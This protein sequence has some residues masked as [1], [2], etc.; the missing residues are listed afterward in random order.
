MDAVKRHRCWVCGEDLGVYDRRFCERW[1]TCGK[2][3]CNREERE[4]LEAERYEA[5]AQLD[6]ERGW[7]R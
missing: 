3:E 5:H 7:I 4:R 1:D 6:R 2:A